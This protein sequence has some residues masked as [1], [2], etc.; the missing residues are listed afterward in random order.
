MKT[1]K[2]E[3]VSV[4]HF[5]FQVVAVKEESVAGSL[6]LGTNVK[7]AFLFYKPMP[8]LMF[9]RIPDSAIGIIGG[10]MG[11]GNTCGAKLSKNDV[12]L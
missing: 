12:F 7:L 8:N 2:L 11:G 3:D 10:R 1:Q 5:I 4:G 6:S 9:T